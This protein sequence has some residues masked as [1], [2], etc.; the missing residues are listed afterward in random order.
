[1]ETVL[2]RFLEAV[3]G[4]VE[5]VTMQLLAQAVVEAAVPIKAPH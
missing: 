1:V 4:G 5:V 2:A 3:V